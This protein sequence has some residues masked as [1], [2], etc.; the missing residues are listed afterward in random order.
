MPFFLLLVSLVI[1][2]G[3]GDDKNDAAPPAGGDD[4]GVEGDD[5]DVPCPAET[6]TF[7]PGLSASGDKGLTAKLVSADPENPH[8]YENAWVLDFVDAQGAPLEDIE[9]DEAETFMPVHRHGGGL[10][11]VPTKLSE[12]GRVRVEKLNF[13]MAGPWEVILNVSSAKAGSDTI[14]FNVCVG[15]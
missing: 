14:V 10:T 3:C 7:E 12:P 1:A 2:A 11:P 5:S 4:A 13:T 15:R 6:P 8:K 9:I